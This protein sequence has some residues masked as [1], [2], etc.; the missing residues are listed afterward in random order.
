MTLMYNNYPYSFNRE[1]M[2]TITKVVEHRRMEAAYQ[3]I[4]RTIFDAAKDGKYQL[5]LDM[6]QF[7]RAEPHTHVISWLQELGFTVSTTPHEPTLDGHYESIRV[8]WS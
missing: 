5:Q 6:S 7:S 3:W 8:G 2:R 1:E 4:I